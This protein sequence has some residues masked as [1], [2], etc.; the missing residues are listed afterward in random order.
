MFYHKLP[1]IILSEMVSSRSESITGHIAAFVLSH[2][3]DV[4]TD[5]IRELA[6][7]AHVSASSISR[8]CREIGLSDY[9]ELKMLA[10]TTTLNFEIC[11]LADTPPQ[12]KDD[13]ISAVEESL[14]RVRRSI[15]MNQ[16]LRLCEEIRATDKIA[17]FGILKAEGVA[18]NLQADLMLLGKTV[19]TKLPFAEQID[20]LENA[21]PEELII[22]FSYTGI[23]F[24]Y[25]T[26][27]CLKRPRSKRPRIWFITSDPKAAASR[28]YDQV[29]WFDSLQNQASHPYQLQLVA[30]LI[31]QRYAHLLRED[32][33]R[34]TVG[35]GSKPTAPR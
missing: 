12:R 10:S 27:E 11:S 15:D 24:D 8:F 13:Y 21:G 29:L 20:Y 1:I 30:G 33:D 6:A 28:L 23:Y 3:N 7:K 35:D 9:N 5:S 31:S 22:L 32:A 17:V 14:E 34:N 19:I 4:R 16:L 18:M 2:L 26:P 25:G